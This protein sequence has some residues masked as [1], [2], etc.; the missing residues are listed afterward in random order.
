MGKKFSRRFKKNFVLT[1]AKKNAPTSGHQLF[2]LTAF[3]WKMM[4]NDEKWAPKGNEIDNSREGG[5][6]W[7]RLKAKAK[8]ENFMSECHSNSFL[9]LSLWHSTADF[10]GFLTLPDARREFKVGIN[11][12]LWLC[13]CLLVE[14]K[15]ERNV[16]Y[17]FFPPQSTTVSTADV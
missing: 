1:F 5:E 11:V 2:I 15:T 7:M 10:F 17:C 14:K 8:E 12:F 3:S 13:E 9:S 16:I 6:K 4:K